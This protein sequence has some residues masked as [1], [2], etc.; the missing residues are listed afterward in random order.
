MQTSATAL[1]AAA[2]ATASAVAQ[3]A[4]DVCAGGSVQAASTAAAT[5]TASATATG[6][7]AAGAVHGCGWRYGDAMPLNLLPPPS[8][9]HSRGQC[10]S[11]SHHDWQCQGERTRL[12]L[13]RR[14]CTVQ[15]GEAVL[16]NSLR[17]ASLANTANPHSPAQGCG[18]A[19][20]TSTAVA[21]AQ[22]EAAS[23]AIAQASCACAA[24]QATASASAIRCMLLLAM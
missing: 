20:A 7:C 1:N 17:L 9:L 3:A 12:F 23:T 4:A 22:A 13:L 11:A 2:S 8:P 16:L 10:D 6:E 5:A 19:T 15:H 21:D 14:A 24:A 18:T